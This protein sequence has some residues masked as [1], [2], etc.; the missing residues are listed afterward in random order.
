MFAGKRMAITIN[1]RGSRKDHQAR[2]REAI[3]VYR[4]TNRRDTG[5]GRI[6]CARRAAATTTI[7]RIGYRRR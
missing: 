3:E 5:S 7:S 4:V 6:I 2:L 1:G